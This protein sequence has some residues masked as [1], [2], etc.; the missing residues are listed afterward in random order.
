MPTVAKERVADRRTLVRM[1]T[2]RRTLAVAAGQARSTSRSLLD[3][4]AQYVK[5]V[6]PARAE[7]LARL[8][9]HTVEDLLYH[10]P[11]RY[12]D[13]SHLASIASLVP[14][15][16][17]A[18]QGVVL[19]L[20]EK[21]HG[22]YQFVA[23]LSDETGVLQAIWFGQ[24]YLRRVIRRGSRL[25]V[26]GRVERSGRLQMM[27]EEFEIL[28]GDD[29]DTLHTG[30]IVPMH[31]ATEGLSPRVLR[32]IIA[33]TLSQHLDGVPDMLPDAVRRRL[34]VPP[35][36]EALQ[37]IHFPTSLAEAEAA[38][39]RLAF[40]ELLV[41][42]LG[43][44]GRRQV[45]QT[46]D[47]EVRYAGDGALLQRFVGSLPYELTRAQR[48]VLAEITADLRRRAPMNRLLQGDVGSG[49]TVVAAAALWLCV[50]GGFQG[51]LMAPTEILAGQHYLTFRQLLAPLGVRVGLV[52]G[53]A[54][55]RAR[56]RMRNLLRAGEVEVAIGTH[57]LLEEGVAFARLGLVVV[58]EQHKFG[59]TQRAALRHKGF[60]P[61][62]L[63]MTATPIPR[64]LSLTLYGDLDVSVLDEM[65]PGRGVVRTY[66]RGPDKRPEVY[67]WVREQA[68][69]GRQ[70]YVVCP[71]IEESE[72]LQVEAAVRLADRLS[73]DA[74]RGVPLSVLHGRM[75]PE[76]KEQVMES[77]RGGAVKVLVATPVIEVGIDVPQATIMVIEDADRF[78]LA[79]LHQLRGRIGRGAQTSH[80]VLLSSMA[81]DA[82]RTRMETMAQ[83]QDGFV[84][85]QRD[86]QLRGPGEILGT[87][88]H[89]LPDLRVADLLADVA[90]LELARDEA[91]RLLLEDPDLSQPEHATLA[92]EVRRRFARETTVAV[93]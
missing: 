20:S 3:A 24:R 26:Y 87:R 22:T 75:R 41:L 55:K 47:K 58:D 59:V 71:L 76:E 49:K 80:C 2:S 52:T 84:I 27:V 92:R 18:T 78:G 35:L 34:D 46:V 51:A 1:A 33:Q 42:Q 39:R 25:I 40:D 31:P 61:D 64:T 86:L 65:P 93:G 14:G 85:A 45:L 19:A 88:Q 28:T 79:Q 11:R 10:V 56:E 43:V 7:Q 8:G 91:H 15:Q 48:R 77:F 72:K 13:R 54:A 57:A 5:G 9:L 6:G 60:H 81:T 50:G 82:A 30:R 73:Q 23:A 83:T 90:V 74:L 63:V 32:T 16:R 12:E 89:G 66:V 53:G 29:D 70:A 4:P 68:N 67:A 44:L 38:H 69:A 36:R 21:R 62:V 37:A 17:Q